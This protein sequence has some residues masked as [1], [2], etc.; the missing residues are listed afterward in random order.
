MWVSHMTDPMT[1]HLIRR[2]ARYSIRRRIPSDLISFY[3][4]TEIQRALGT[5]DRREAERLVRAAGA[6]LDAEFQEARKQLK[7]APP[8]PP[9]LSVPTGVRDPF[10]ATHEELQYWEQS[11]HEQSQDE[12]AREEA[13]ERAEQLIQAL[14]RAGR[15]LPH[16][17]PEEAAPTS[18]GHAED[19]LPKGGKAQSL[20][21]LVKKW[22]SE[23]K[24][25]KRTIAIMQR[26]VRVFGEL[27]GTIAPA[28]IEPRHVV[29]FKDALLKAKQTPANTN[30]YL[31]NLST[32]LNYAAVNLLIKSNPA[33]GIKVQ[34]S[35][36]AKE[37][38]RPWTMTEL[39]KLLAGPVHAK[40][41]RPKGGAGEAAYWLPLLGLFTGARLEELAQMRPE[42]VR[43]ASYTD[44]EGKHV[45]AWVLDIADHGEGQEVK[46]A[47]SRRTVP[48]HA[49]LVRLGFIDF[50]QAAK[51]RARLFHE[52]RPDTMGAEAGNWGKWF[53]KYK[54]A[55][56][57]T[58]A[59][60]VFHSLRHTWKALAREAGIPEDVSDAITG[61][62]GGGVGRSY[63][64]AFPLRPMVEAMAR[65]RV[66]G[67]KLR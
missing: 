19:A 23:R 40:G 58:D 6:A 59:K 46:T 11:V 22:A 51:G 5:S 15:D 4:K 67:M 61:H 65:Y 33:R 47:S 39:N 43:E 48:A 14:R 7:A 44:A 8:P 45:R 20:D 10:P 12:Y 16:Y 54:R 37:K 18:N 25:D 55:Q 52:L 24:P 53:G 30:S 28:R 62:R 9:V 42:D 36:R 63:G 66:I 64:G 2:G 56:G 60:V 13:D 32:L 26:V 27:V 29:S 21:L 41:Q 31:T 34:V 35:K 17:Q 49:E 3:S 1:T 57:V 38:R 50:A